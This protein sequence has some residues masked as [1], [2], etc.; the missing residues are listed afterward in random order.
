MARP[1]WR[2]ERIKSNCIRFL[3][4]YYNTHAAWESI[5]QAGNPETCSICSINF[6]ADIWGRA[7]EPDIYTICFNP[8]RFRLIRPYQTTDTVFVN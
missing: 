4:L 8:R 5:L 7:N 3:P 6:L 2:S 1:F